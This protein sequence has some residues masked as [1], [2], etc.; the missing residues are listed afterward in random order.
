M[1]LNYIEMTL[2]FENSPEEEFWKVKMH[3]EIDQCSSVEE[4]R[5]MAKLLV[6]IAATRQVVIKGL[7]KD[8]LDN[9]GHWQLSESEG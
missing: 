5:T 4:L 1:K 9:M 8:A 6:S 2:S 3:R 7:I